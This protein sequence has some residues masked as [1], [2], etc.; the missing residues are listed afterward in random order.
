[1]RA[2]ARQG[3][4]TKSHSPFLF[5]LNAKS[6]NKYFYTLQMIYSRD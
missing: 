6:Y 5:G 3:H 2:L 4:E 1:M